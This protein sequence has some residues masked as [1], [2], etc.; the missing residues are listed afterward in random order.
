MVLEV[1]RKP[2]ET[3]DLEFTYYFY[4]HEYISVAEQVRI[5]ECILNHD[6]EDFLQFYSWYQLNELNNPESW[7]YLPDIISVYNKRTDDVTKIPVLDQD[8]FS[9]ITCTKCECG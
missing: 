6:Y 5:M 1:N 9:L 4:H 8:N 3:A 2:D 7:C